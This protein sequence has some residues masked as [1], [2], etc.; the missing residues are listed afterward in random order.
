MLAA[1]SVGPGCFM[2]QNSVSDSARVLGGWGG[3][4]EEVLK[5]I[6]NGEALPRCLTP[7]PVI[8]LF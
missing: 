5:E 7:Y 8:N 6:L 1:M 2:L 3:G 4:G